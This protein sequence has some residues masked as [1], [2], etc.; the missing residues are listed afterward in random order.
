MMVV[1]EGKTLVCREFGN[2][3]QCRNRNIVGVYGGGLVSYWR[4]PYH[5]VG[6]IYKFTLL[7][8]TSSTN[9]IALIVTPTSDDNFIQ[10]TPKCSRSSTVQLL[11]VLIR[12]ASSTSISSA[13]QRSTVPSDQLSLLHRCIL[14]F[15]HIS[16]STNACAHP[17]VEVR[18]RTS[19]EP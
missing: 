3:V 18:A 16:P 4:V 2:W 17:R 5:I 6:S 13:S 11:Q 7:L 19:V 1:W 10:M 12:E 14:D 8:I 15:L 9:S